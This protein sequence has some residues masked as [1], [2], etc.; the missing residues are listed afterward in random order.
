MPLSQ[1]TLWRRRPDS[2][3]LNGPEGRHLAYGDATGNDAR[4]LL[5]TLRGTFD[6]SGRSRRTEVLHYWIAVALSAVV[7]GFAIGLV[8]PYPIL[9]WSQTMLGLLALVPLF[10]LFVRRLHDQDRPGWWGLLLP[11]SILLSIPR[12]IAEANGDVVAILAARVTPM[13]WASDLLGLAI[14]LL[15]L[16]PGTDGPNRHGP[17]PRF[18]DPREPTPS[19]P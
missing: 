14:F 7:A 6:F 11:V 3:A 12:Q 9:F 1:W 19:L 16:W 4:L 15:F 13:A 8:A 17:D 2:A 5:R 18:D 10:A